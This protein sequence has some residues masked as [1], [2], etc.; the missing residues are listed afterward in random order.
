MY[1]IVF[2]YFIAAVLARC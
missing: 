2:N 1:S